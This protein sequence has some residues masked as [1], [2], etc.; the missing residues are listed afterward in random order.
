MFIF[1]FIALL[2]IDTILTLLVLAM[3]VSLSALSVP[4]LKRMARA[5]QANL[6]SRDELSDTLLTY[7]SL[8]HI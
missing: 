4:F 6:R 7:L 1:A 5:E 3:G 8:I 2:R